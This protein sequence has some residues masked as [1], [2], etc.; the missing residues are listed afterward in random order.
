MT[1]DILDR[2]A[3]SLLQLT[4]TTCRWPIGDPRQP[5]FHFCLAHH[6]PSRTYCPEH[7]AMAFGKSRPKPLA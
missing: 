3:E 4:P 7:H 5:G 2:L 1:S 6:A